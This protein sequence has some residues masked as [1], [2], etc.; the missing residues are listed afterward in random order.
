MKIK[1][2]WGT[3]IFLVIVAFVA[4]FVSFIIYSFSHEINLVSED[5]FPE[6]IAYE[7]TIQ[8]IKN[9]QNLK[10]S[11]S[12]NIQDELLDVIFPENFDFDKIEGNIHF[13]YITDYKQDKKYII[14]LNNK[15]IFY[16]FL[17]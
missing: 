6:E 8:K 12:L 7:K 16:S 9:T 11:V 4:F 15:I 3:G 2:N 14:D 13:F 17:I 1:F 10:Q 5:Y